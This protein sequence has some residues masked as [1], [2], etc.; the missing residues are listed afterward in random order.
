MNAFWALEE[1]FFGFFYDQATEIL[2][3]LDQ[4][5]NKVTATLS[6]SGVVQKFGVGDPGR[7]CQSFSAS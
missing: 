7:Y 2:D 3:V 1:E 5:T 4:P 6:H